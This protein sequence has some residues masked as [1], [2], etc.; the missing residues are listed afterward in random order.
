MKTVLKL[1]IPWLIIANIVS[2]AIAAEGTGSAKPSEKI[3]HGTLNGDK[4]Q[5]EVKRIDNIEGKVSLKHG[6]LKKLNMP[7]MTMDFKVK[8]S[9]MLNQIKKGDKV[10][11]TVE[12]I[13]GE[14]VITSIEP[15]K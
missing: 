1:F 2:V 13:D 15:V 9:A 14:L 12:N 6:P 5:A 7:G 8:D 10:D 3:N 11:F 4:A